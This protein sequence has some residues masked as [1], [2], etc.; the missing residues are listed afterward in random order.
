ML[1]VAWCGSVVTLIR[2]KAQACAWA[3][4]DTI[5]YLFHHQ[6]LTGLGMIADLQSV[7]I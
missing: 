3:Y 7:E 6:H 1:H 4:L 2:K 5:V